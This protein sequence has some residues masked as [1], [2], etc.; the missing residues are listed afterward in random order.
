MSGSI[1]RKV[2]CSYNA[3]PQS[4]V[5]CVL[6]ALAG[7]VQTITFRVAPQEALALV[8]QGAHHQLT[9][10]DVVYD[11]NSVSYQAFQRPTALP[12]YDDC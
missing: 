3:F 8:S 9:L 12:E 7:G 4:V 1:T 2:R 6:K 10:T 11:T 5:Y